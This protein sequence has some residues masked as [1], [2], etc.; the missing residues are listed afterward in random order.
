MTY[1]TKKRK[2]NAI[3]AKHIA[4]IADDC[5][6]DA[7]HAPNTGTGS[8]CQ[9][10]EVIGGNVEVNSARLCEFVETVDVNNVTSNLPDVQFDIDDFEDD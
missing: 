7:S 2:I 4:E 5:N 10:D 3:V 9:S 6:V 8:S 1:W